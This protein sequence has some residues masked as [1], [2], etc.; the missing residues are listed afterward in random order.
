MSLFFNNNVYYYKVI[1]HVYLLLL[2][3]S[4]PSNWLLKLTLEAAKL[5]FN[6]KIK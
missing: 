5:F 2:Y 6:G 3:I 4:L 1:V